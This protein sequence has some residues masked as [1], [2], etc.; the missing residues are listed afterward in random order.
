MSSDFCL[1]DADTG[2][3][4]TLI[5]DCGNVPDY[6]WSPTER[7]VALRAGD[8]RADT[9]RVLVLDL[10]DGSVSEITAGLRR[11]SDPAWSPDGSRIAFSSDDP[12]NWE[13][14]I[15]DLADGTRTR[16]TD[17]PAPDANPAWRPDGKRLAYVHSPAYSYKASTGAR[18][19]WSSAIVTIG[20]DG[21]DEV[22][23]TPLPALSSD[24]TWS[25]GGDQIAYVCHRSGSD[26][27]WTTDAE[28]ATQRRLTTN[29]AHELRPAWSPDGDRLVY[30]AL[31]L[32]GIFTVSADG[33][34]ERR[35]IGRGSSPAW[36]PDGTS[37]AFI[38]GGDGRAISVMDLASGEVEKLTQLAP[39][40]R[41]LSWMPL[42]QSGKNA[43][44]GG[45][46]D[47]PA[48]GPH[49]PGV[50]RPSGD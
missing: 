4:S 41:L 10:R 44:H 11:A 28:G 48:I 18:I 19:S 9:S 29:A 27:I 21:A 37:L 1:V 12:G 46:P 13:V 30:T 16:L 7:K 22:I 42:P 2:A 39:G 20:V 8:V 34:D 6:A 24:P 5:E 25:P 47:W 15:A 35:V 23:C 38:S 32:S 45:P 17:H 3:V 33:G 14:F 49:N 26:E 31:S 43:S 50:V 40:D 36:S